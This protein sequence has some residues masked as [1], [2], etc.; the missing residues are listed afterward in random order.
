MDFLERR[1]Y[2]NKWMA[3]RLENLLK[4]IPQKKK[5]TRK[6]LFMFFHYAEK[7]QKYGKNT[8]GKLRF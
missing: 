7:P 1:E 3:R 4:G 5:T 6:G 8:M 2:K